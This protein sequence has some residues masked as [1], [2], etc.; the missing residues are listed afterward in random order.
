MSAHSQPVV[1][2]L[3]AGGT[4]SRM[5]GEQPKQ[6]LELAGRT[7]LE[8]SL[9]AFHDHPLVDEVVVVMAPG[10]L[11][12]AEEIARGYDK[13]VG[14]V[15][16]G[17]TRSESTMAALSHLGE[18]EC[19]VLVHDAARPLV[20]ARVIGSCLEALADR[21]AVLVA[22]EATDTVVEVD[23]DD[24]V[25]SVPAR[26][27][28]RRVQTPQGFRSDVLRAAYAAASADPDFVA[29][30]DAS[31]VLHYLPGH[32]VGVVPGEERNLKVT[33]PQDLRLAEALLRPTEG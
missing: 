8:H 26:A 25:R 31:V 29:T 16:G 13:V 9:R 7:I 15:A 33:T 10:H 30:D 20:S 28:L 27:T 21:P 4:G 19:L 14:V 32:S 11:A 2:V 23:E 5:G 3:L 6:L 22:V 18:R 24:T 12:A 1:A 17:Q